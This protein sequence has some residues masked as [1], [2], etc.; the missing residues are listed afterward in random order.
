MKKTLLYVLAV[1]TIG[2]GCRKTYNDTIGGQT[3]DE[4]IAAAMTAYQKK[5]SGSPYGWIMIEKTTGLA[6]N[7][8]VSQSGPAITLAYYMQFDDSNKVS[9]FSD[10][11]PSMLVTSKSSGYRV[12]QLTRPALIFDTYSYLHVPCDPDPNISKSPFGTGYGWGTDFE[13]SFADSTAAASLGD[14]IQLKGNLNGATATL[15]KATQAQRDAYL[16]G[17]VSNAMKGLLNSILEYFKRLTFGGTNYELRFDAANRAVTFSWLDGSGNIRSSTVGYYIDNT[18]MV[19]TAPFVNGQQ[20]I[21]GFNNVS[22]D[23]GSSTLTVSIGGQSNSIKGAITPLKTDLTAPQRWWQYGYD[24]GYSNNGLFFWASNNGFHSNGVEDAF[25]IR[26][27]VDPE[28]TFVWYGYFCAFDPGYDA[29]IPVV[30]SSGGLSL[31]SVGTA[32]KVPP[33]FTS[34]GRLIFVRLG[35]LIPTG[36]SIPANSP[37][38][39]SNTALYNPSGYYFIQTGALSY[40]MVGAADAK[41]WISWSPPQ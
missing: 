8:G 6:F 7:G 1:V 38:G 34:D 35:N 2:S 11:D 17:G 39:K 25:G 18:G 14:T 32:P 5:L 9:M 36:G 4:R 10:F 31:N 40:D 33:N 22:F 3:P 28:G 16:T 20:K 21:T 19:F 24:N 15:I 13:F 30:V 27:N 37:V 23:A 26:S 12:K 29:F 41:T